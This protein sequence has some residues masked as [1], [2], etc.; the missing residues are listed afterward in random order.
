MQLAQF[1]YV[2]MELELYRQIDEKLEQ[3]FTVSGISLVWFPFT[4]Q[5]TSLID[6]FMGSAVPQSGL[7]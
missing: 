4:H 5:T 7:I 1:M 3:H 6:P 2:D